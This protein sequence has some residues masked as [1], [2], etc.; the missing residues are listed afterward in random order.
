MEMIFVLMRIEIDLHNIDLLQVL[1]LL[2]VVLEELHYNRSNSQSF[3]KS[4][5][6]SYLITFS[7]SLHLMITHLPMESQ[8]PFYN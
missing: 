8:I 1:G 3:I 4:W 5:F 6:V 7:F 2:C